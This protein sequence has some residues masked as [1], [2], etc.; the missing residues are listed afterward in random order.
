MVELENNKERALC[1]GVSSMMYC[2]DATKAVRRKRLDQGTDAGIDLMLGGCPKCYMHMQCMLNEERMN[3]EE[4]HHHDY[5]M[6]D[7]MQFLVACLEDG[8]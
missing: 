4:G 6:M 7:L 5:E 3:P 2:N 1:C 8:N